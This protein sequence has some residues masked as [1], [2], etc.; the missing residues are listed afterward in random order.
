MILLTNALGTEGPSVL[1]TGLPC[2]RYQSL[3]WLFIVFCW[4]PSFAVR[5]QSFLWLWSNYTHLVCGFVQR[6]VQLVSDLQKCYIW[7]SW[8]R[9]V[10]V[11]VAVFRTY[12]SLTSIFFGN[13]KMSHIVVSTL[14]QPTLRR[15]LFSR[16]DWDTAYVIKG[17]LCRS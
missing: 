16:F 7:E 15:H 13:P 5:I 9:S 6:V 11:L 3:V 8:W 4:S 17:F 12:S 10:A 1:C 2:V 14:L